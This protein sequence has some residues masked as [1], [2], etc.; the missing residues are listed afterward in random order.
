M[1]DAQRVQGD[2]AP[3]FAAILR[4]PTGPVDL[5]TATSVRFQMRRIEAEHY[6]IDA[7]AT[8]GE[9]PATGAVR[10]RLEEGDLVQWGD[11]L[12]H[13]EIHWSDGT[14]QT[15]NPPNTVEVRRQ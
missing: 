11:F 6:A 7:V 9:D 2:T 8:I 14:I 5:T 4:S 1:A 15:T 3:D 13:W 10:Y 12:A